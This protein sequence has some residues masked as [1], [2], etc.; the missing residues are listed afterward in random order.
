MHAGCGSA[1]QQGVGRAALHSA[2]ATH[3][4]FDVEEAEQKLRSMLRFR[5]EFRW[6]LMSVF[7]KGF[8][9]SVP[10]LQCRHAV[11]PYDLLA[12]M[13]AVA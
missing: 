1:G 12:R 3:R 10:W 2:W 8:G 5:S 4:Y 13:A 6:V 9:V 11:C 7:V